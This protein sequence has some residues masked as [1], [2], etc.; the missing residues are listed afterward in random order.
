MNLPNY[1]DIRETCGFKNIVF[2]NRMTANT[3]PVASVIMCISLE[4]KGFRAAI[5]LYVLL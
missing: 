4:V 3:L 1:S 5:I 2:A